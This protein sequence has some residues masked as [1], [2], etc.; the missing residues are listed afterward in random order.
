MKLE[1]FSKKILNKDIP[2]NILKTCLYFLSTNNKELN[3][4]EIVDRMFITKM[5]LNN[6]IKQFRP[7]QDFLTIEGLEDCYIFNILNEEYCLLTP[8]KDKK[9]K[10]KKNKAKM[11]K[12]EDLNEVFNYWL[13]VMNKTSRTKL[14]KKRISVINKALD[15]L[16]IDECKLAILGC[17]KSLWH[18]AKHEKN[19]KVLYNSLDVIFRDSDQIDRFIKMG[20]DLPSIEEQLKEQE[21]YQSVADRL[22]NNS[23][24]EERSNAFDNAEKKL[25]ELENKNNN[26][27]ENKTCNF[28]VKGLVFASIN[29]LNGNSNKKNQDNDFVYEDAVF[30]EINDGFSIGQ[31]SYLDILKN[32]ER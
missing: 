30:E 19:N 3:I 32:K 12:N 7:I 16:T 5:K 26:L 25:N 24:L 8:V 22:N 4:D 1:E 29:Y 9:N 2:L 18:M 28:D 23:W 31:D 17:S 15:S 14:D 20:N 10:E 11:S 27:L 21:K 6:E 13:L